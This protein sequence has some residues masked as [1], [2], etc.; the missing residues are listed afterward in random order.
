MKAMRKIIRIVALAVVILL[1]ILLAGF[2]FFSE[3]A[4][5]LGVETAATKALGVG[6]SLED[7]SISVIGGRVGIAGLVV[8]NPPGYK[9][10]NLLQLAGGTVKV[11]FKDLFGDI[12]H[13]NQIK[14]DG[15]T[16]VV[17]Q[18]GLSNNLNEIIK[19]LPAEERPEEPKKGPEPSGKKLQIDDLEITDINVKVKLLPLPGKADTIPLRIGDIK[20]QNLGGDNKLDVA[21][22]TSKILVAIT[23]GIAEQGA[24]SLPDDM[25]NTMR[26]TLQNTLNITLDLGKGV[27][28][29]GGKVIES[30]KGAGENI[31]K[32]IKGLI[33]GK[34]E[35]EK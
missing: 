11:K 8:K 9:N 15:I 34:K 31:I 25:L 3:R 14:L 23:K 33:P 19:S 17:E 35:E 7:V 5:K 6:V 32:G 30:G 18:K 10:E 24:G 21:K 28:K 16:L 27:L 1:I 20:M 12:V 4:V 26:S 22:L 2:Y 29:E 13:I